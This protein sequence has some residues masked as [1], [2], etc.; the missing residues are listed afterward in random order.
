MLRPGEFLVNSQQF[1]SQG[2]R[3]FTGGQFEDYL[4]QPLD[5]GGTVKFE[6]VRLQPVAET[7]A[8]PS[9]QSVLGVG[10]MIAAQLAFTYAPVMNRLFHSAPI[11]GDGDESAAAVREAAAA[12]RAGVKKHSWW[13]TPCAA[14]STTA[15]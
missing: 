3:Q 14:L 1:Q 15:S 13:I 10:L 2:V 12:W 9:N 4:A 8:A 6:L 7:T 5:T 11:S